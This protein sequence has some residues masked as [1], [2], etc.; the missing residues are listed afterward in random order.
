MRGSLPH[1]QIRVESENAKCITTIKRER[2]RVHR[3]KDSATEIAN[4]L[5]RKA[6][7]MIKLPVK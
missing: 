6:M 3:K 1:M 2:L 4:E 5:I 7:L